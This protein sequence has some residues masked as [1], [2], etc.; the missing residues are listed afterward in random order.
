VAVKAFLS[1]TATPPTDNEAIR[2]LVSR[3]LGRGVASAKRLQSPISSSG[4]MIWQGVLQDDSDIARIQI[5]VPADWIEESDEPFLRL[6]VAWDPPVNAAVKQ[7]WSTRSVSAKLR[8]NPDA[9]AQRTSRVKSHG[10]YPLLE[11]LYDLRKLPEGFEVEGDLW[12][13]EIGYEQTAEYHAAMIFPPQQR[14]AFAA[15]LFDR[16]AKKLSPQAPLQS[17][18]TSATMTRLSIP[19]AISRMPVV[20]KSPI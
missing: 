1:L 4:V 10:T 8:L 3:T 15:E 2:E 17:L 19:P 6:I 9:P 16:G 18:P 7:L 14:V 11:R 5:P 20:L 13:V 12:L